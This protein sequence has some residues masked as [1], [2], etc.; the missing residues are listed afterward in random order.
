MYPDNNESWHIPNLVCPR[1]AVNG[2]D[3]VSSTYISGSVSM[4]VRHMSETF[5]RLLF[6]AQ[7]FLC[8]TEMGMCLNVCVCVCVCVCVNAGQRLSRVLIQKLRYIWLL[9][10]LLLSDKSPITNN[11]ITA[12]RPGRNKEIQPHAR[13]FGQ[14][15]PP[16]VIAHA[17]CSQTHIWTPTFF[18][19]QFWQG[20]PSWC[21]YCQRRC[22]A[23]AVCHWLRGAA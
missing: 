20:N 9:D 15:Q 2:W 3:A 7:P 5:K 21:S 6:W 17:R 13:M 16:L 14:E 22:L 1:A 18:D 19:Q 8:S 23:A 4:V 11:I 10:V 12:Q